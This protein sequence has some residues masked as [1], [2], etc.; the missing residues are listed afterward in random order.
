MSEL[1]FSTERTEV[2][3]TIDG[4]SYL[5]KETS[6]AEACEYRNAVLASTQMEG[7]RRTF[8]GLANS[9]PLLVSLCLYEIT[10]DGPQKRVP[11]QVI[12]NW[13]SKVVS[14]LFEKA[15]EISGI[16]QDVEEVGN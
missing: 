10:D 13:P 16:D 4:K 1:N 7:G 6:G 2:P 8:V 14:Q 12:S 3:V 15:K 9:E 5:L 11:L